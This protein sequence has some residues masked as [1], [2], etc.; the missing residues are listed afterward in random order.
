MLYS[1]RE[2]FVREGDRHSYC[3]HIGKFTWFL[4]ACDSSYLSA[5]VRCSRPIP[6]IIVLELLNLLDKANEHVKL[7]TA[8]DAG[9]PTSD[10]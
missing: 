6:S 10:Y 4:F 3:M 5:T 1:F 8:K 9:V 7:V 2:A